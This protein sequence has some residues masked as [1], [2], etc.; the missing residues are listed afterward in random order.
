MKSNEFLHLCLF[1]PVRL[2]F[3]K[4]L[5]CCLSDGGVF[6]MR[7][8]NQ[9][10]LFSVIVMP[11][12][13]H[14]VELVLGINKVS[15]S[16]N[17]SPKLYSISSSGKGLLVRVHGVL[18]TFFSLHLCFVVVSFFLFKGKSHCSGDN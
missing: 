6:V 18:Y 17:K 7:D 2:C 3:S 1:T 13:R 4:D 12:D 9:S 14:I 11:R 15:L 10:S 16:E 5:D 8:I